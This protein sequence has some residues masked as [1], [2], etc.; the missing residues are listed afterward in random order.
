ML[1]RLRFRLDLARQP[2][3]FLRS[4]PHRV[5]WPLGQPPQRH[6][7]EN[8]GRQSLQHEQPLPSGNAE[9]LVEGQQCRGER[10][11]EDHGNRVADHEQRD[12]TRTLFLGKPADQIEH[13]A[14]KE[15]GFGKAEQHAQQ[16][17]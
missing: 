10:S 9:E 13:D 5:S 6:H 1:L 12:R 2:L 15:A 3:S 7:A 11:A 16:I 4:K 17:E 8:D 14:R